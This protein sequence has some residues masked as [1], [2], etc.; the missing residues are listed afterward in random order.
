M[1]NMKLLILVIFLIIDIA[2]FGQ[3]IIKRKLLTEKYSGDYYVGTDIEKERIG[4]IIIYPETDSTVLFYVALN[5]GAPSYNMGSL[6]GRIVIKNGIG[7]FCK[8]TSSLTTGCQLSFVFE[9]KVLKIR[10]IDHKDDC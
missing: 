1:C 8:K 2:C 5:R 7:E 6:Y 4:S 10:T 9:S 3:S